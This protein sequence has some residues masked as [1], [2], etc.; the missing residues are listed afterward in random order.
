MVQ[1][2]PYSLGFELASAYQEEGGIQEMRTNDGDT[3]RLCLEVKSVRGT[4][5][6]KAASDTDS[7]TEDDLGGVDR[8]LGTELLRG[9]KLSYKSASGH[10]KIEL[11][12]KP[13]RFFWFDG[14]SLNVIDA[15]SKR[16]TKSFRAFSGKP[17]LTYDVASQKK[18]NVGCTPEG[19]YL[20]DQRR[21]LSI[22]KAE[23]GWDWVKWVLKEPAWG[24]IYTPLI[25][26]ADTN[27][28]GRDKM[29]VH[30]GATPGSIG[31]ID[32]VGGN[33]SFH[34]YFESLM[35]SAPP[36]TTEAFWAT[37]VAGELLLV[38]YLDIARTVPRT[39]PIPQ[40]CPEDTFHVFCTQSETCSRN[41]AY[42]GANSSIH[43]SATP[44]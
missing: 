24:T 8:D 10:E 20:I 38:H 27:T 23:A 34:K 7:F 1:A 40:A 11:T 9:P 16:I 30:G 17:G 42:T 3:L 37:T 28:Y 41:L 18:K 4:I 15:D 33:S 6:Y 13:G 36:S 19:L 44:R 22:D 43:P 2:A 5:D 32:L 39:H 21:T 12:G 14:A 25:P 35:K 26:L 29:F 31:C